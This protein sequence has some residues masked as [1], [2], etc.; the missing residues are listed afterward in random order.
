MKNIQWQSLFTRFGFNITEEG[1]HYN[2]SQLSDGNVLLLEAILKQL[3]ASYTLYRTTLHIIS[4]AVTEG[5]WI[6]VQ[7]E[8]ADG[9]T[10]MLLPHD[11]LPLAKTD[12]YIAVVVT[13]FN[14]LGFATTYSCDGHDRNRARLG[15][16]SRVVARNAFKF[17]ESI[18]LPAI[19]TGG[20]GISFHMEREALP[21][22]AEN[23]AGITKEEAQ[24]MIISDSRL[25]PKEEYFAQLETLLNIPGASGNEGR[26]R[27]HVREQLTP[28]VD[29]I[30][31]DEAG[32]LLAIKKY[33]PGLTVLLNAH[34]DTVE[35]IVPMRIILKQQHI[36]S[37]SEGIL[38]ADD[39]AGINV[40]LAI[41]KTLTKK[42]FNGT[43]KYI[44]T[45]EEEI[46]LCGARALQK[47]FLWDV[48]M[49]FVVDRRHTS[50]IV[51]SRGETARFCSV[52]FA[53][54]IER[55]AALEEFSQWKTTP[56][57]SS[58]TAV[59]A[60]QGI[61]S[62][63]LSAGYDFEH[64]DMEQLDVQANYET[65]EFLLALLENA[66]YLHQRILNQRAV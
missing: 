65:H 64:T 19:L 13:Q 16:T 48:D 62:V 24:K 23:M 52:Q 54:A 5:E 20:T 27:K 12:L 58:D 17:C 1:G 34:L 32:N 57:G 7:G 2:V 4:E 36:W 25:L 66:R 21:A 18:Q 9:V 33:G 56:G 59:W 31:V 47:T 26:I 45:V 30:T 8:L 6:R 61:Q 29:R 3:N 51:I 15:F 11:R 38:G 43:I 46:G 50:D 35:E 44:F 22:F 28:Y 14:R 41:A 42:Q 60:S 55:V 63:N 37:S 53:R 39:R 40:L 10:E 49:A